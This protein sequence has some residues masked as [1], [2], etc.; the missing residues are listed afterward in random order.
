VLLNKSVGRA[1]DCERILA[2]NIGIALHDVYFASKIY[3]LIGTKTED[4]N[5]FD[6]NNKFGFRNR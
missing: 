6:E 4:L 2:Y 5:L 1:N 3:D